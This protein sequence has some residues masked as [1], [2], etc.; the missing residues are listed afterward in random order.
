[1]FRSMFHGHMDNY[2]SGSFVEEF[3]AKYKA[4]EAAVG[5]WR[6]DA[7]PWLTATNTSPEDDARAKRAEQIYYTHHTAWQ[8]ILGRLVPHLHWAKELE[9][10][11]KAA[12]AAL[13]ANKTNILDV[14]LCRR[15]GGDEG[16]GPGYHQGAIGG[17]HEVRRR[18]PQDQHRDAPAA[19]AFKD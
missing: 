4:L 2:D 14:G 11:A 3:S 13:A 12:L 9:T 18:Y 10:E 7:T 8:S 1:M 17:L 15:Q 5:E 19:L 16:D 6:F